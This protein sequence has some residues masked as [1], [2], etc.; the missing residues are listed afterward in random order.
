MSETPISE[1]ELQAYADG[2][3]D[4]ATRAAV[5]AW[6]ASRPEEAERVADYR[7][8]SEA[9]RTAYDAVLGEPVLRPPF[10]PPMARPSRSSTATRPKPIWSPPR[11]GKRS[12]TRAMTC[13][14]PKSCASAKGR[15]KSRSRLTTYRLTF[16]RDA[17]K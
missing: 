6:L 9:L 2:R 3:L 11:R 7:R 5:E 12:S 16:L 13:D 8:M 17:E 15:K 10:A 4:E 1:T 14:W